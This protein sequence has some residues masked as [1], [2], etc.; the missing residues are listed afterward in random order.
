MSHYGSYIENNF[1]WFKLGLNIDMFNNAENGIILPAVKFQFLGLF[2][3]TF[4]I[5]REFDI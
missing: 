3:Q 4:A 5:P 1:L 2:F